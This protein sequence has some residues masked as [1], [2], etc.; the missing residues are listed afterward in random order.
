MK[1]SDR[2]IKEVILVRIV[3]CAIV[4]VV[5]VIVGCI[6]N[7]LDSIKR[8][9]INSL[10]GWVNEQQE[11]ADKEVEYNE[12]MKTKSI[13]ESELNSGVLKILEDNTSKSLDDIALL[14][15]TYLESLGYSNVKDLKVSKPSEEHS[16]VIIKVTATTIKDDIKF[17]VDEEYNS[18]NYTN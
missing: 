13:G 11:L 16:G 1:S 15:R 3:I 12:L 6:W 2:E 17:N 9:S 4:L 14:C 10:N 8:E 5:V 18:L 7:Y